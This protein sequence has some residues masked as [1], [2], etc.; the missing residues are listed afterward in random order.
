MADK[1]YTDSPPWHRGRPNI[2]I[3]SHSPPRH[4]RHL[5][6]QKHGQ[7]HE[8]SKATAR[9]KQSRNLWLGLTPAALGLVTMAANHR[10]PLVVNEKKKGQGNAN[11]CCNVVDNETSEDDVER[12]G[13]HS[14]GQEEKIAKKVKVDVSMPR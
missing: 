7:E 5:T 1:K 3:G 14:D 4:H 8:G 6:K 9:H 13:P 11:S 2:R 10:G 12:C